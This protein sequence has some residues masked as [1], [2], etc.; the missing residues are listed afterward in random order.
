MSG[1]PIPSAIEAESLH[2][3]KVYA[4]ILEERDSLLKEAKELRAKLSKTEQERDEY[5]KKCT[6]LQLGMLLSSSNRDHPVARE[7]QLID[8]TQE[9]NVIVI[10]SSS[11]CQTANNKLF[12]IR[13]ML[14]PA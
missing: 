12:R 5:R 13:M 4:A 10:T 6:D 1:F 14:G 7:E 3:N 9:D 11:F 8:L 2:R